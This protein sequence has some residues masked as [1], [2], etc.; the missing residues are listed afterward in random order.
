MFLYH[1]LCFYPGAIGF[2]SDGPEVS[3]KYGELATWDS[4]SGK[5]V[6]WDPSEPELWL[7]L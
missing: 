4:S 5:L 2:P 7:L 1:I 6:T 3:V